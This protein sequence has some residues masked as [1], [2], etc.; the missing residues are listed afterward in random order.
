MFEELGIELVYLIDFDEIKNKTP[1]QFVREILSDIFN[2]RRVFCGFNYR[3][4]SRGAGSTADLPVLCAENSITAEVINPVKVGGRVASSTEIRAALREGDIQLA[5]TLLGYDYGIS[6]EAVEGKHLGTAMDTPTINLCFEKGLLVPRY[7]VYASLVTID[8]ESF[9]GVTNIGVKPTVSDDNVP[10]CETWLP[11]YNGG[12][13]Y[14]KSVDVRLR[15]FIRPERKFSGLG[16]LRAA[17]L[18]DGEEALRL[19]S[20]NA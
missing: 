7:G 20:K 9:A 12:A 3:F 14:G 16:E 4:G 17:I 10:N 8:G 11:R 1:E 13:L 15:Q 2:A 19:L 18:R 5:N 6:S